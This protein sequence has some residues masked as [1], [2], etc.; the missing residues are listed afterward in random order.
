MRRVLW[1]L[2]SVIMESTSTP[3]TSKHGSG[4]AGGL[5]GAIDAAEHQQAAL[6]AETRGLMSR[7]RTE[8]LRPLG[9]CPPWNDSPDDDGD[10]G[11]GENS[12]ARRKEAKGGNGVGLADNGDVRGGGG[13]TGGV[14]ELARR[15]GVVTGVVAMLKARK[16]GGAGGAVVAASDAGILESGGL[17]QQEDPAYEAAAAAAATGAP[18]RQLRDRTGKVSKWSM[19]GAAGVGAGESGGGRRKMDWVSGAKGDIVDG[20]PGAEQESTVAAPGHGRG[21]TRVVVMEEPWQSIYLW[22]L[23]FFK[24]VADVPLFD[25]RNL[26]LFEVRLAGRAWCVLL[27]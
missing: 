14:V 20:V 19:G 17:P 22:N 8:I 16:I 7:T 1:P 12:R 11:L 25:R 26:R 24:S 5:Q 3:P 10:S 23:L 2:V 13:G 21:L 15:G 18:F 27:D 4:G 6:E 9:L